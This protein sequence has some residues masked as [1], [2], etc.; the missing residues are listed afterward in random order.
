MLTSPSP[1]GQAWDEGPAE[2]ESDFPPLPPSNWVHFSPACLGGR[3]RKGLL[4]V[5]TKGLNSVKLFL[6]METMTFL[7]LSNLQTLLPVTTH[8]LTQLSQ[9]RRSGGRSWV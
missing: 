1:T 2:V 6:S 3:E 4:Q 7:K 9:K 5:V 8:L